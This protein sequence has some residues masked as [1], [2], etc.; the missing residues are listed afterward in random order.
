MPRYDEDA[1]DPALSVALARDRVSVAQLGKL[2]GL[3]YRT[4]MRWSP[5]HQV[6]AD[7][8]DGRARAVAV[9]GG[10]I[11]EEPRHG[12]ALERLADRG[13][14]PVL[15]AR[16]I[17]GLEAL[18]RDASDK[19]SEAR[20]VIA[21]PR[22]MQ[23]KMISDDDFRNASSLTSLDGWAHNSAMLNPAMIQR[24]AAEAEEVRGAM[25]TT[26]LRL[27]EELKERLNAASQSLGLSPSEY[28]RGLVYLFTA[29]RQEVGS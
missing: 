17:D 10:P 25:N 9:E 15:V 27:P 28:I 21:A 4:I 6:V 22:C 5:G 24:A 12:W 23:L 1:I 16:I 11:G 2:A 18:H 20:E 7:F 8:I 13:V 14:P 29:P 19:L 3:D 26:S